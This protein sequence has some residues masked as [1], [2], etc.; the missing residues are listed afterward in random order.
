MFTF[1]A[2]SCKIAGGT[3]LEGVAMKRLVISAIALCTVAA[4]STAAQAGILS[5]SQLL[6]IAPQVLK[7]KA[8]LEMGQEKCGD[9]V[10]LQPKDNLLMTGTSMALKK[11][12]PTPRFN[13]IDLLAGRQAQSASLQPGFCQTTAAKKPT[14]L[15]NI[16]D[17]AKLLGVGGGS[18]RPGS[19]GGLLGNSGGLLGGSS[20]NS[21]TGDALSGAL[22]SVLGH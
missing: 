22:G 6:K 13:A 1:A 21:G 19:S 2:L 10:D 18:G 4:G 14:I 9:Q 17:S 12:L 15:G 3:N 7:G 20:G 11:A 8:L 16:A 5:M